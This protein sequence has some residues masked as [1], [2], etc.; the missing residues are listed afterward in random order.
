[1]VSGTASCTT[2]A[3]PA[4][5]PGTYPVTCTVGTLTAANYV[6]TVGPPSP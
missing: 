6:F 1:M 2:T 3:G 4:S 5:F